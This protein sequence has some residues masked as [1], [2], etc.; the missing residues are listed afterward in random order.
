[1]LAAMLAAYASGAYVMSMQPLME[2]WD[3]TATV[4]NIGMTVFVAGF[5]VAPMILAPIS[6]VHGR[7]WVFIGAGV[8]F[9]LGTLGC[10]VTDSFAGMVVSR[11]ITGCGASVYATLTGGAIADVFHKEDRN[12]PMALYSLAIMGG[13]GLGPLISGV[14]VDRAGW[15]WVFY[16]QL[17]LIAV[18]TLDIIFLLDETRSN[19]LLRRKC[20]AL[21]K[22]FASLQDAD[23]TSS[24]P[25]EK[26]EP[27]AVPA[28]ES[29]P[30]TGSRVPRIRFTA[31]LE[32][33]KLGISLIWR[34]FAFPLRLLF[35]ESVV[36]WFSAWVSFAWA[37]MYM[38]FGSI[39]LVFRD[40]Y[41]FTS[42]QV[43][44]VYTAVILGS[45]LSASVSIFIEPTLQRIWPRRMASPEG[46]LL[47][48][49]FESMFLPVGLFWFGWSAHA[50]AP[51]IVPTLAIGSCSMGIFSVYLA[52]LNYLADTYHQYS[53]SAQAA[54]SMCRNLLAGIFPLITHLLW[55]DLSYGVAGSLL[56]AIG[57][58]LTGVPWL[59]SLFGQKIRARSP[60][61]GDLKVEE[62]GSEER[63]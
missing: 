23:P 7:Y 55:G 18:S 40:T 63:R 6:E 42:T 2:K 12:T 25:R 29:T 27:T 61:A 26:D 31:E 11:F 16:H 21:N 35:T 24:Q 48:A 20:V 5:G 46:R 10:A 44:A 4:F 54:Q 14:I 59:L 51:W 38:Q 37:I 57:F 52:V 8:M 47:S 41:N 34:S 49:C 1:M 22:Y 56:G 17:I 19:V 60:F 39:G 62:S 58:L 53:S 50:E 13:A 43:G 28:S 15:K 3:L 45:V 9:L 33:P 30:S 32:E 36:F